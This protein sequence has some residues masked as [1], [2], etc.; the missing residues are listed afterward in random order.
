MHHFNHKA[1]AAV[2]DSALT[3]SANLPVSLATSSSIYLD[4]KS[5]LSNFLSTLKSSTLSLTY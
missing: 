3:F 2:Y 1:A 4:Y 5:V